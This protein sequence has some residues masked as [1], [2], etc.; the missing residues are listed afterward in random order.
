M[1]KHLIQSKNIYENKTVL[2]NHRYS[3][4][5]SIRFTLLTLLFLIINAGLAFSQFDSSKIRIG[6]EELQSIKGNYFNY[7]D[8]N[9]INIEVIVIGGSSPG[10]YL[11]PQGTTVFELLLM[12]NATTRRG[13]EDIKLVRFSTE[14][15]KLK[16]NEVIFLDFDNL[17]ADSKEDIKGAMSNPELKPGDM[18][19]VPE[20]VQ[21]YSFW[22]YAREVISY[23]GTFVSFYY[24]IYN[25]FRDNR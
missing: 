17:Y 5:K 11:I 25:I 8:K 6:P 20:V 15:P 13:V 21:T 18:L 12:A 19:V 1:F 4:L 2:F 22:Y 24:L 10:K 9:K 23:V 3:T 16:G 14:T 7:A